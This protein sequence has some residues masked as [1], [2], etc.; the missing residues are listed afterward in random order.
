[1]KK[2][3]FKFI[4]ILST[5]VFFALMSPLANIK[6]FAGDDNKNS[7]GSDNNKINYLDVSDENLISKLLNLQNACT[8]NQDEVFWAFDHDG[9]R[10]LHKVVL[11]VYKTD[12]RDGNSFVYMVYPSFDLPI[13]M[14]VF[15][16]YHNDA[17]VYIKSDKNLLKFDGA[18]INRDCFSEIVKYNKPLME[19]DC[20]S[21]RLDSYLTNISKERKLTEEERERSFRIYQD[22]KSD[23]ENISNEVNCIFANYVHAAFNLG[24][25]DTISW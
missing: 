15:G 11:E 25:G 14:P 17:T 8:N 7:Q 19:L 21:Y 12:I 23:S 18:P 22:I 16:Y 3:L 2:S 1:M 10:V 4:S 20:K 5:G 6:C 9:N 24:E 13:D